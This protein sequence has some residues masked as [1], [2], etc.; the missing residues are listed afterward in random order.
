MEIN[1]AHSK[2]IV[3][4]QNANYNPIHVMTIMPKYTFI[5]TFILCQLKQSIKKYYCSHSMHIHWLLTKKSLKNWMVFIIKDNM[6]KG[7][8]MLEQLLPKY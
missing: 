7:A 3:L 1:S 4:T 2:F 6:I 5:N 8:E